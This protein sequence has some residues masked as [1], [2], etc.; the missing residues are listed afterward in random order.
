MKNINNWKYKEAAIV[1]SHI[2]ETETLPLRPNPHHRLHWKLSFWQPPSAAN[3]ES[4]QKRWHICFSDYP[5]RFYITHRYFLSMTPITVWDGAINTI[6]IQIV[7]F[8]GG[9]E[10]VDTM[11]CYFLWRMCNGVPFTKTGRW[12]RSVLSAYFVL[13]KFVLSWFCCCVSRLWCAPCVSI[14]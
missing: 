13:V 4:D 12:F 1:A 9:R 14:L 6:H 3:D 2:T 5:S 8:Y 10:S 7:L 11:G